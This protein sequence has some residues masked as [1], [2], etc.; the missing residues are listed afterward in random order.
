MLTHE[1]AHVRNRD[2]LVCSIAA[3][4]ATAIMYVAH[5]VQFSTILS[6]A[7]REGEGE[8]THGSMAGG[9]LMA[10]VAPIAAPVVQLGGLL[11]LFSTPPPIEK[12]VR[13]LRAMAAAT[14]GQVA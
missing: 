14:W 3:A 4:L 5:A 12:R 9:L 13:R 2:I 8:E 6:G 11:K 1:R 10:L 7:R